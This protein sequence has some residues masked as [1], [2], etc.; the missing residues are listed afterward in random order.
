MQPLENQVSDRFV[1]YSISADKRPGMGTSEALAGENRYK[2]LAKIENFRRMLSNFYVCNIMDPKTGLEF[3]SAEHMYHYMKASVVDTVLA[4]ETF[5]KRGTH[6]EATPNEVKRLTG[7]SSKKFR[8]TEGQIKKWND[9]QEAALAYIW[10]LKF[11]QNE[12]LKNMLLQTG[13]AQL[14]HLVTRRG[15]TSL[16]QRWLALELLRSEIREEANEKS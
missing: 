4:G 2:E 8:F 7:K 1:F 3:H 5:P 11:R 13:D 10:G 14:V 9:Q 15:D 16:L 6:G 12:D